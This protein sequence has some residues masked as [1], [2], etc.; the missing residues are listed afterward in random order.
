MAL[1]LQRFW[2]PSSTFSK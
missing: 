1:I 2:N